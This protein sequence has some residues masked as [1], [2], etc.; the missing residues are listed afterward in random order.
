[1]PTFLAVSGS[2]GSGKTELAT[3]L[4]QRLSLPLLAKD[5]IKE[6]LA[7]QTDPAE[8]TLATSQTVGALAFDV[9]YALAADCHG[10]AVLDAAWSPTFDPTGSAPCPAT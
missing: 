7:E 1:M 4:A 5:T 3:P 6:V 2:P 10:G 8:L 9:L